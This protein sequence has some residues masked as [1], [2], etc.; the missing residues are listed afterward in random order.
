MCAEG[1]LVFTTRLARCV[2]RLHY[3][4]KEIVFSNS[5]FKGLDVTSKQIHYS[6]LPSLLQ[7]SGQYSQDGYSG[8][9]VS[10]GLMVLGVCGLA[11]LSS[12]E[13]LCDST[14]MADK[15]KGML[16]LDSQLSEEITACF[17]NNLPLV[18]AVDGPDGAGKSSITKHIC[19]KYFCITPPHFIDLGL[20]PQEAKERRGWYQNDDS[21]LTMRTY[22]SSH[23]KRHEFLE[24]YNKGTHYKQ[25][26]HRGQV[27]I[28]IWDRG[29]LSAKA[30]AFAAIRLHTRLPDAVIAQFV[31][32]HF[33]YMMPSNQVLNI[34][35]YSDLENT[36]MFLSR[37][38]ARDGETVDRHVEEELVKG[39]ILF[40]NNSYKSEVPALKLDPF[41][42]LESNLALI[43]EVIEK[44]LSEKQ[45]VLACEAPPPNDRILLSNV[46]TDLMHHKRSGKVVLLGDVVRRGYAD[47]KLEV[48]LENADDQR[49]LKMPERYRVVKEYKEDDFHIAINPQENLTEQK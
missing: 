6:V 42:K 4:L 20:M 35:L 12:N 19:G 11:I 2:Q 23:Q 31:N 47:G 32:Q 7:S 44:I 28:I 14:K 18:I 16:P 21:F 1:I 39:Q 43:D 29:P 8:K 10:A 22:L 48:Y 27:P 37:I 38:V 3:P 40:Y 26:M 5:S 41:A 49:L 25:A 17:S 15:E 33:D 13:I 45:K 24:Q 36:K 46:L 30:Y 9:R 34:T